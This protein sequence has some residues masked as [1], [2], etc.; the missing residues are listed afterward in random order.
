L[1]GFRSAFPPIC[2]GC[3]NVKNGAVISLKTP[4]FA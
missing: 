3:A 2:S 1:K 4:L